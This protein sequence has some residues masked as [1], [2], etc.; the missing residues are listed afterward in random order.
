MMQWILRVSTAAFI[1]CLGIFTADNSA[2]SAAGSP[3]A[4]TLSG[5]G[6]KRPG[7]VSIQVEVGYFALNEKVIPL[8]YQHGDYWCTH[9]KPP[10]LLIRNISSSDVT[11][12]RVT[13]AGMAG[14]REAARNIIHGEQISEILAST[15]KALNAMLSGPD[16]GVDAKRLRRLYGEPVLPQKG[17]CESN[18][19]PP[20]GFAA[21]NL[22]DA[23]YFFFEGKAKADTLII[24]VETGDK[25]GE[26]SETAFAVPLLD[27]V[28][29]GKYIYPVRG[30]SVA[31]S[32]PFG[33]SHRFANGQEFAIDILDIRRFEDGSFSTCRI[34]NDDVIM[35]SD[36]VSEY[37][38]FGREVH[39]I[40]DGA[41]LE[42]AVGF[43]DSL[44][45][46]PQ[47]FFMERIARL[48]PVLLERGVS[49]HNING[50]NFI[51]IDHGNGEFGRYCH[52]RENIRVKAGDMVKQGDV[53]GYVGNTGQSVEPHLHLELLDSADITTA[54]GLP[55]VF[56]DLDLGSALDSPFFGRRNS[57]LFSEF[58][59][60]HAE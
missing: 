13:V 55:V 2:A 60:I 56:E 9:V 28:C 29:S 19:L 50:G 54:N 18:L 31:G 32:L 21:I 33:H 57:L 52:L 5:P 17:Y 22:V 15:N 1:A 58:I 47:D 4:F 46:N 8:Y 3:G 16:G 35:G 36:N 44:A 39:A 43:P 45:T 10:M 6:G 11:L 48:T 34:P 25:R 53:I 59:F 14:G 23:S 30:C 26:L 24:T 49:I 42:V 38:I 20:S 51:L 27:Y 37:Y 7:T 41:V 40:G 12:R